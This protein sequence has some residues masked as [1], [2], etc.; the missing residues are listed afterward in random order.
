MSGSGRILTVQDYLGRVLVGAIEADADDPDDMRCA[1]DDVA[2]LL[3]AL[4]AVMPDLHFAA[5]QVVCTYTGI[6]PLPDNTTGETLP[7]GASIRVEEADEDRP[8]PILSLVGGRFT[9]YRQFAETAADTI[10]HRLQRRRKQS[11]DH[12]AI[13]GGRSYPG[14][15]LARSVWLAEASATT[16]LDEP[17]LA[18]LLER[19]GT[20]A[21]AIAHHVCDY[22][23]ADRLPDARSVSLQEIDWIARNEDVVRLEDIVLRRLNLGVASLFT[24]RDIEAIAIVAASA[25]KWSPERRAAE[26][27]AVT[28][29]LRETRRMRV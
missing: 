14:N 25:L 6:V 9:T 12:L 22:I 13:G 18:T 5:D 4:R 19:Y 26:I 17:R 23:D 3:D 28:T 2:A 16:K 8:F 27:E 15:P 21:L 10:L 11:T 24:A 20:T 1:D 29:L 7:P